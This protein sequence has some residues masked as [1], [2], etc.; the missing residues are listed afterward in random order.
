[1]GGDLMTG[2]EID[3]TTPNYQRQVESSEREFC[4]GCD[5]QVRPECRGSLSRI[6]AYKVHWECWSDCNLPCSFCYR[7]RGTPLRTD[8]AENLIAAIATAGPETVVF[9]G[10]DPSLRRDIGHLLAYARVLGLIT[11]VHTNAQYAPEHYRLAL[12]TA[13]YVGLSLDGPSAEVHDAFRG[14]RG[15]FKRVL[16]LFDFLEA[17]AIPVVVRTVLAQPNHKVAADIGELLVGRGNLLAWHLLEFSPVGSGFH[18]SWLYA[19]KRTVFDQKVD[20]SRRRFGDTIA[21]V[22]SH[23]EDKSGTYVLVTPDG[24]AYGTLSSPQDGLYPVV[25]SMLRDH[26]SELAGSIGFRPERH[27]ELYLAGEDRRRRKIAALAEG[28]T[29]TLPVSLE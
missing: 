18:N 26:L 13:D 24:Q 7:T 12:T 4:G 6:G 17:A 1:M 21:I 9:T 11:E 5:D 25:G 28:N 23:L 10:G 27:E 20:E 19:L 2:R 8:E 14:K 29:P 3:P 15:N 16:D 22:D